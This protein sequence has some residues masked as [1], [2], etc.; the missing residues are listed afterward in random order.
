MATTSS[1]TIR[2]A[3]GGKRIR[4]RQR[5]AHLITGALLIV[6]VYAPATAATAVQPVIRWVVLP[7]LVIDGLLMWQWARVRRLARRLRG[8]S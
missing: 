3:G 7:L 6:Y 5:M 1:A 4:D 8:Q 2:R